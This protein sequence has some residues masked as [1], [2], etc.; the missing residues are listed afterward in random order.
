MIYQNAGIKIYI[1][2][3]KNWFN[4]MHTENFKKLQIIE[5]IKKI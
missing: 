4:K 2:K 5:K 3:M 1:I